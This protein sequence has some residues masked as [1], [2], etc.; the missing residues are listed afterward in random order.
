MKRNF[1]LV[2]LSTFISMHAMAQWV[3]CNNGMDN[4]VWGTAVY[5]GKLYACGNFEH[6][7]GNEALAIA[8]WDGNTWSDVGGGFQHNAF[9][10]VVMGL[11]VFND[12]L[13]AGGYVDSAGG[14]S[15]HK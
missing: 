7:D 4:Y 1:T 9:S 5:N 14:L 10:T 6:A 11:T 13:I 2:I 8:S 12:E 3:A 15:I